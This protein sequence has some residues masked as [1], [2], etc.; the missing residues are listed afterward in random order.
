MIISCKEIQ[1][2]WGKGEVKCFRFILV[3]FIIRYVT[4]CFENS[5]K[6][7]Y[8]IYGVMGL[9]NEKQEVICIRSYFIFS[10]VN[11]E[12]TDFRRQVYSSNKGFKRQDE[13]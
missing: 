7:G 6:N 4:K 9:C 11:F 5:Q 12:T 2:I 8:N 13:K 3:Y 10:F 1:F